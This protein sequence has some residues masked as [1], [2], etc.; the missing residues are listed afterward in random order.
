MFRVQFDKREVISSRLELQYSLLAITIALVLG[1]IFIAINKVN[2][3]EAYWQIIKSTLG[4][5]YGFSE[6]IIK[7]IPLILT[8]LAVSVAL[9]NKIWNIGA[10]G[11]LYFGAFVATAF[12]L[13]VQPLPRFLELSIA[14]C[15]GIIGGA[16]WAAIPAFLKTVF[17]I[18]EVITTLLLNYVALSIIDYFVFGPWKGADNFPYTAT[19][20]I[21][22]QFPGLGLGRVHLG[23][24]IAFILVLLIYFIFK[25]TTFGYKVRL[26]GSSL[27]AGKYAGVS[28]NKTIFL[29]FLISGG[30]AGLA[31]VN[32]ICGIQ[33]Q[34][35]HQ[36]SSGYGFTGI[37]VAWL[38]RSNPF[39]VI[40]VAF[41]LSLLI[42]GSEIL[43]ISMGLP[44][45]VG[46]ILQSLILFSILGCE[47]FKNYNVKFSRTK[48]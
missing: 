34:L 22:A 11:Q 25:Y 44:A 48:K 24:I 18:N 26:S 3:F 7:T 38:A 41:F 14:V 21:Q 16:F 33:H 42:T 40:L 1:G 28:V 31:G 8:G 47:L 32:E 4:S 46:T 9:N 23:L 39:I 6:T 13:Y 27:E 30:L 29:V 19:F 36:I 2:P 20:P 17:R 10:E 15:L 12:I 5:P 37:I 45:S 35:H 43:Q